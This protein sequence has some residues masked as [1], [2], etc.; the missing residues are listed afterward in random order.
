MS[1][2]YNGKSIK[3]RDLRK[4][5]NSLND[6]IAEIISLAT[7]VKYDINIMYNRL[8][9]MGKR[10]SKLGI[11]NTDQNVIKEAFQTVDSQLCED[12]AKELETILSPKKYCFPCLNPPFLI[13]I[14]RNL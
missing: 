6:Y 12:M 5:T 1:P 7:I 9:K 3:Y 8:D 4:L 11:Y 10:L 2:K 14:S 13:I